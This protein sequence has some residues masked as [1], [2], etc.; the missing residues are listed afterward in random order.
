M[1]QL[2]LTENDAAVLR[3]ALEVY[4]SDLR[5]E[6]ADT[7]SQ[8]FRERLKEEE[9]ILVRTVEQLRGKSTGRG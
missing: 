4:L 3:K 5:M 6:V 7:D 8:D 1:V 9:Q 2:T